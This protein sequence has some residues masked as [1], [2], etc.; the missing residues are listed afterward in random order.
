VKA[1]ASKAAVR[2]H[3]FDLMLES[4]GAA[5]L[6]RFLVARSRSLGSTAADFG[7]R[8]S[9]ASPGAA[10]RVEVELL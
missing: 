10:P 6:R 9:D 5:A 8:F 3:E 2:R 1:D 7:V 4:V